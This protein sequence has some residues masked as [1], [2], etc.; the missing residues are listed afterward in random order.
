[1]SSSTASKLAELPGLAGAKRAIQKLADPES[2]VHA[3]LLYGAEGA[4]KMELANALAQAWLCNDPKPDGACGVCRS[5][6]AFGRDKS[7][8]VLRVNPRPPS[9][10]IKVNA[11]YE[12]EGDTDPDPP[13]PLIDF[14]RTRALMGRNK[15]AILSRVDRMNDKA[16]NAFLKTLE[17][18]NPNCKIVMTTSEIGQVIPTI[19]SR[20]V[21]VACELPS[22]EEVRGISSNALPELIELSE[23]A[24]GRLSH[25]LEHAA[26]YT[27]IIEFARKVVAA[28]KEN[29]LALSEEFRSICDDLQDALKLG[30]RA[31]NVEGLRA[32]GVALSNLSDREDWMQAIAEGHR[33]VQG[34]ANDGMALDAMFAK[35][36]L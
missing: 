34:N 24:P 31:A 22:R 27:K 4:G 23:G 33:R 26:A 13:L 19:V 29:A 10:I 11:V 17:E 32:L 30:A 1:M 21:S 8:D 18:P 5:C 7:P 3:V 15:V 28:P 12:V 25:I 2:G 20:C 14:F 9:D 16:A 6:E 36:L 35:M